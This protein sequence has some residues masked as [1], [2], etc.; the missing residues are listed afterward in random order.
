MSLPEHVQEALDRLEAADRKIKQARAE[1]DRARRIDGWLA[2]LTDYML[3][4]SD[5][6]ELDREHLAEQLNEIKGRL[7]VERF[8]A[9]RPRRS[10]A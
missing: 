1:A 3:A 6:H 5:L 2:G 7:G 10:R 9:G 4:L 8:P